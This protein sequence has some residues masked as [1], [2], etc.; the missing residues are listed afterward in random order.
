MDNFYLVI[1]QTLILYG[2]KSWTISVR[3]VCVCLSGREGGMAGLMHVVN[4]SN[5]ILEFALELYH[6]LC[7]FK[8]TIYISSTI[9]DLFYTF[10]IFESDEC[11]KGSGRELYVRYIRIKEYFYFIKFKE[12]L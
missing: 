1:V 7:S 8:K 2:S 10:I 6:L 12:K 5:T 3:N 11:P 9:L 4:V